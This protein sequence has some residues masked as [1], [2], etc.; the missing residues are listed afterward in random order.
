MG[1][2][3]SKPG[4]KSITLIVWT[5]NTR[6]YVRVRSNNS[7]IQFTDTHIALRLDPHSGRRVVSLSKTYLPPKVLVIPRKRWLYPNMTEKLFTG[8]LSIKPNQNKSYSTAVL[9][10]RINN[11]RRTLGAKMFIVGKYLELPAMLLDCIE[12]N[13]FCPHESYSCSEYK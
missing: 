4:N 7:K 13:S 1:K 2:Y 8:T 6:T 9:V 5:N 10:M 12:N 11:L 3:D